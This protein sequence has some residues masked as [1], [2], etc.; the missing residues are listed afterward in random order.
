MLLMRSIPPTT[1]E[2]ALLA[3]IAAEPLDDAPRLVYADWLQER[4]QDAKAEYARVVVALLHPP[5]DPA[6]VQRCVAL[7][8]GLD[9]AWRQ[10]VG[11]RFEVVLDGSAALQLLAHGIQAI[12]GLATRAAVNWWTPEGPVRLRASLT[13]EDAEEFVRAFRGLVQPTTDQNERP[14]RITVRPMTSDGPTLFAPD[15]L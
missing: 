10:T 11:G 13:R 14:F 4:G 8:D 12:L 6:A 9:A 7:A 2:E 1:D 5:E 3:A 15:D